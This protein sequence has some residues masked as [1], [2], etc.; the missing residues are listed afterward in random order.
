MG[1]N[2]LLSE[3]SDYGPSWLVYRSGESIGN[4]IVSGKDWNFIEAKARLCCLYHWPKLFF[5]QGVW[6]YLLH[7][8]KKEDKRDADGL[9]KSV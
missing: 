9:R 8:L 3:V 6:S 4:E 5:I 1:A 2:H 7:D